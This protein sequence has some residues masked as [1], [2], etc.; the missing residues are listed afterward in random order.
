MKE[1]VEVEGTWKKTG[2]H[3]RDRCQDF[4]YLEY[5]GT[6]FGYADTR[7]LDGYV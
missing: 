1:K 7:V 3:P 2:Y 4:T 5:S 6:S